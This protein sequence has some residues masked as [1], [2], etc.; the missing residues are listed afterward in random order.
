MN[1][2]STTT[3]TRT[4][5]LPTRMDGTRHRQE[6][7]TPPNLF[8]ETIK[9][10]V[11][12]RVYRVP[13]YHLLTSRMIREGLQIVHGDDTE[14]SIDLTFHANREDFE[15]L[16]EVLYPSN[17]TFDKSPRGRIWL[18]ALKLATRLEMKATRAASIYAIMHNA[19]GDMGTME[20]VLVGQ[21]HGVPSLFCQ[22]CEEF[23]LRSDTPTI[24]ELLLLKGPGARLMLLREERIQMQLQ[25][26]RRCFDAAKRVG[27]VFKEDLEKLEDIEKRMSAGGRRSS[28]GSVNGS[29][30]RD[31]DASKERITKR[32]RMN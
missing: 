2:T 16:I 5:P 7:P 26:V 23:V 32:A 27:E 10:M 30:P 15:N 17:I 29:C 14:R 24:A 3:N 21:A 19:V 22:G 4:P 1:N 11:E 8:V 18:S 9:V 6:T 28:E 20:K 31:L 13:S 25:G 12:G